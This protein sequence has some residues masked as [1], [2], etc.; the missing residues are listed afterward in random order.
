MTP[1]PKSSYDILAAFKRLFPAWRDAAVEENYG[2][3]TI[4]IAGYD[5]TFVFE[6]NNDEAWYLQA[7]PNTPGGC[8][9]CG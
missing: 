8:D 1:T 2:N 7:Y 3:N 9:T 5:I 4:K 6:Y